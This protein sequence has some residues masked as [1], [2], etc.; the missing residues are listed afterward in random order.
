MPR[1]WVSVGSNIQPE[2]NVQAAI[3]LAN[4]AFGELILSP[5]Y[6][7]PA[8]GFEGEDFLN[9]VFGFDTEMPVGE[10]RT[11]LHRIE[12]QQGRVRDGLKFVPRTLDLDLLTYGD[13]VSEALDIPRKEITRYAFVLKPLALVAGDEIHPPSGKSYARLWREFDQGDDMLEE[14]PLPVTAG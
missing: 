6:K 10:V 13:L 9:L 1:V 5:V 4:Q 14:V 11:L 12:D 8:V 7:T 2:L 3:A